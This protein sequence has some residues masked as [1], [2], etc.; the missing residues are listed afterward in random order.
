MPDLVTAL[1]VAGS[2]TRT[3]MGS[4]RPIWPTAPD[5]GLMICMLNWPS[6]RSTTMLSLNLMVFVVTHRR[7]RRG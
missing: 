3:V 5:T 2:V 6:A 7:R 1:Q 4:E